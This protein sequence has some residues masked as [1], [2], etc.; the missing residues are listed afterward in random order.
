MLYKNFTTFR[1]AP[2]KVG[3]YIEVFSQFYST[4]LTFKMQLGSTEI[5][6]SSAVN[7]VR[8]SNRPPPQ[9]NHSSILITL[10]WSQDI[11][12]RDILSP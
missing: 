12:N 7:T 3:R 10:F 5:L 6:T 9:I 8:P 11:A 2:I 1:N 4:S